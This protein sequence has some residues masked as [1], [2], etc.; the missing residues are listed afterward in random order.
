MTEAVQSQESASTVE[1][2]DTRSGPPERS[3]RENDPPRVAADPPDLLER[4]RV[5]LGGAR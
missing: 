1:P 2:W 4:L 5:S 3:G